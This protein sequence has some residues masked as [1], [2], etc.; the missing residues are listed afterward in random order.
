MSGS[1]DTRITQQE[2]PAWKPR[3]APLSVVCIF[4][5][6]GA[7]FVPLGYACLRASRSV[8]EAS[9]RYDD[10]CVPGDT[11][12]DREA[13]LYQQDGAGTICN[14]TLTAPRRMAAPVFVYYELDNFYQ[15]HRR[16]LNSKSDAQ[17]RGASASVASLHT[18]CDPE[19]LLNGSSNA[20]IDPCGLV[21]WS[22]FNDTFVPILDGAALSV[23]NS[24]IAWPSDINYKFANAAPT[25]FNT[26][27]PL[28]GG[29]TLNGTLKDEHFVV[30]MRAA[31]LRNFRKLWGRIDQDIPAGANVTVQIQ[32]RYNTYAFDGQKKVVLSTASWLGGANPFIGLAFLVVGG[33]SVTFG[34]SF[35]LLAMCSQYKIGDSSRLSWNKNK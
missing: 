4:L 7:A 13:F 17:L 18:S 9:R 5:G 34:L 6:V 16:Y 19:T 32:N 2:L 24:H 12:E 27:P 21:A 20:V 30:W 35:A 14:V 10:I 22:Y 26:D 25:N 23:D 3:F 1:P 29:G 31:A 8:V 15:N 28:R 11:V 33:G